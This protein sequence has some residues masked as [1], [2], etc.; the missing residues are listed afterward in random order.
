MRRRDDLGT[1]E[2]SAG[3]DALERVKA[4]LLLCIGVTSTSDSEIA[5]DAHAA[6]ELD[7]V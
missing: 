4:F 7:V 6:L 1:T 5:A 2:I 3:Q